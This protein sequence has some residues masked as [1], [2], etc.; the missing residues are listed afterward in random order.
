MI[1]IKV[2]ISNDMSEIAIDT[3]S[4][5]VLVKDICIAI[6]NSILDTIDSY[7]GEE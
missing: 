7:D 6:Q 1:E 3:K 4:T 2:L 5:G